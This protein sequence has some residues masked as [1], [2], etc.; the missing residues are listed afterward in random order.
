MSKI[1]M[2]TIALIVLSTLAILPCA[3]TRAFAEENSQIEDPTVTWAYVV[4]A[5]LGGG[6]SVVDAETHMLIT[7]IPIGVED[8]F[9]VAVTPDGRFAYVSSNGT[10]SLFVIRTSDNTLIDEVAKVSGPRGLDITPDGEYIYVASKYTNEVTIVR[11]SDKHME[12]VAVEFD[13]PSD[14]AITADG[15]FAYVVGG[16]FQQQGSVSVIRTSDNSLVGTVSVGI[17]TLNVAVTPDGIAY[18]TNYG[19]RLEEMSGEVSVITVHDSKVEL[20]KRIPTDP[21]IRGID[22]CTRPDGQFAYVGNRLRNEVIV[23]ETS[24]NTVLPETV[25]IPDVI[26]VFGGPQPRW[27]AIT[28]DG[29]YAY[30]TLHGTGQVA[31]ISTADNELIDLVNIGPS[32]APADAVGTI[33][34]DIAEIPFTRKQVMALAGELKDEIDDL[35]WTDFRLIGRREKLWVELKD[36][37][38]KEAGLL[39]KLIAGAQYRWAIIPLRRIQPLNLRQDITRWLVSDTAEILIGKLNMISSMLRKLPLI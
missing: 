23:I 30:V 7:R 39:I 19:L 20:I 17:T 11:L 26:G 21:T 24:E 6:V 13:E 10:D 33:A 14:V 31:V 1:S 8:I 22:I 29:N 4:H 5:G 28:P 32:G 34:I 38:S 2:S 35:T 3:H 27:V 9:D 15:E 12:T 25:S 37:L 16:V 18:V 36:V